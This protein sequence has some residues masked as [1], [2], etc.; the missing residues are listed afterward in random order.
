[1]S[2]GS[3]RGWADQAAAPVTAGVTADGFQH[4]A[5]LHDS[6]AG[7]LAEVSAFVRAA[8]ARGE[9]VL[10]TVPHWRAGPLRAALGGDAR[11]VA[12]ADTAGPGGNPA[13]IIPAVVAFAE[14][15]RGARVACVAECTWPGRPAPEVLEVAKHEALSNLAYAGLPLTALCPYGVTESSAGLLALAEQTHP[16]LARPASLA[17]SAAYLGA[18][19]MPPAC[20]EPLPPP[21]PGAR[22][23]RYRTGLREVR[24]LTRRAAAAAGLSA[25]RATDLVIA[26]SEL[27]ANTLRHTPDGGTLRVWRAAGELL[28]EVRDQGWITDPLVGRRPPSPAEPGGDGLWVVNQVCDLA[29]LRTGPAGTTVRLHMNLDAPPAP[30][31]PAPAPSV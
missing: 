21:P 8:V 3:G 24:E 23:C 15:H 1:V 20:L 28:C 10:L 18:G 31:A 7:Y 5:L 9:P 25:E 17:G 13:R 22:T 30:A 6:Q 14:R 11:R 12:F 4:V 2:E 19:A 27:A 16:L 26:V 29:E